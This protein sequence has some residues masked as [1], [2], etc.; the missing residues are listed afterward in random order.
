[1][2][3]EM[4]ALQG[5]SPLH[6][7]VLKDDLSQVA[8]LANNPTFI[9][10]T[11]DLGF[12]PLEL[13]HFLRKNAC[14]KVLDALSYKIKVLLR[15]EE[16]VRELS[17]DAFRHAFG[18]V[19]SPFL[20]FESY[21][22][23]KVVIKNC[24]WILRKSYFGRENRDLGVLYKERLASGWT[25]KLLIKWMDERVG[26]GL[27]ADE[28]IPSGAFVGEYTGKVRRLSKKSPDTNAYC[29]HYPTRFW[30][31]N[32]F[33]IDALKEG[34]L[35][36]FANHSDD[37]NLDPIC[38]VD[39]GLLHHAFFAKSTISKGS[40]LTFNYGKDYWIRR[41]KISIGT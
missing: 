39:R 36:R 2:F 4:N 9:N 10:A 23:F 35:F 41:K 25:A 7:A 27:F 1:M 31:W 17:S 11:N 24:P 14:I 34:N 16:E 30:S 21:E 20:T 28:E 13:A 38:L 33:A 26:Y 8:H 18:V 12:T 19:F 29:F 32:I 6:L 3:V 37:P 22:F 40:Q 15:G 5:E